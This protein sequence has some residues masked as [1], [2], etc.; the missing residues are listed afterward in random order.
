MTLPFGWFQVGW[1]DDFEGGA[2][3]P[4]EYLGRRL[5]AW[6]DRDQRLYVADAFCSHMGAHLGYGGKVVGDRLQCPFHNWEFGPD[7][8]CVR[9]PYSDCVPSARLRTYPV[10][11]VGD[12]CFVWFHD[13]GAFPPQWDLPCEPAF[14]PQPGFPRYM[15]EVS[16]F[17]QD[18][19]ENACDVAHFPSLHQTGDV[20][21]FRVEGDGPH[22]TLTMRTPFSVGGERVDCRWT[23]EHYGPGIITNR[24]DV[25][26]ISIC[27]TTAVTPIDDRRLHLRMSFGPIPAR[28]DDLRNHLVARMFISRFMKN[29]DQDVPI[30]E[31]KIYRDRPRVVGGDGPILDHRRWVAQFGDAAS[32]I[33]VMPSTG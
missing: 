6:L 15:R 19:G 20:S 33:P 25:A 13:D 28:S 24:V 21:D 30:F 2:A 26:G 32:A 29:G 8:R 23:T 16:M 11:Y 1:I 14:V 4:L 12:A 27:Q 7:G 9:V 18:V 3:V 5:V 31:R 17:W 10:D 22:R